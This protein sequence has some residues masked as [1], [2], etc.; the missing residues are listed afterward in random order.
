MA[1]EAFSLSLARTWHDPPS[2]QL[3]SASLHHPDSSLQAVELCSP[4]AEPRQLST[5]LSLRVARA[6]KPKMQA[7][8]LAPSA[9]PGG[10]SQLVHG[11]A[12]S[13][14]RGSAVM[15]QDQKHILGFALS[16][17]EPSS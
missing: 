5:P 13:L 15:P 3:L 10:L 4:W 8:D 2:A 6:T 7:S 12:A 17:V 16:A 9:R 14:S 1:G 11:V